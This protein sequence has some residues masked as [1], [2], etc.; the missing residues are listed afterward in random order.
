MIKLF[1]RNVVVKRLPGKRLKAF[2]V[3][4]TQMTGP[5]TSTYSKARWRRNTATGGYGYGYINADIESLRKSMYV[6]YD[7]MD[8]DG[9]IASALDLYADECTT[10]SENG[11]LLV[12][13]SENVQVKKIL[14]NLFYD[15]LNIEFNLWSWMRTACKYGDY[16]LFMDIR[17]EYGVVNVTPCHPGLVIREEGHPDHPDR[18]Q[19]SYDGDV[20]YYR[21]YNKL[22][23]FEVAHFRLITDPSFLPYGR[24]IIEPARKVYKSLTLM[25]DAMLLYRI[26]R[27]PERRLFKID[28]GLIPPDE[29]DTYIESLANTMKKTPIFDENTGEFNM[30][31]NIANSMED[32]FIPTRGGE[33]GT[34]IETLPGL[35]NQGQIDDINYL[36]DKMHAALKIPRS[37]LG[38]E[39]SGENAKAG[40]ATVDIRFARTIERIQKVFVSELY[41]IAVVHLKAQGFED[42]EL[43]NFELY[44]TNPS[45]IYERQKIELLAS[46]MELIATIRENNIF[47]DKY[48]YEVILNMTED[49]WIE[50]HDNL[51]EDLKER[52]RE[53][54]IL[55]EGNDPV[56]SGRSFGTPHAIATIH[57]A[58]NMDIDRSEEIKKLYKD[59]QRQYNLGQPKKNTNFETRRNSDFGSDPTGKKGME[60]AAGLESFVKSLQKT[61]FRKILKEKHPT[62]IK[63]LN[64]NNLLENEI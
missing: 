17:E 44:L 54:Q 1:T 2:D 46:K 63:M 45:L 33:S 53:K 7:L 29:I 14:H 9:L 4:K 59:D 24:S 28:V 19:F 56:I 25:E 23:A 60:K 35:Q 38:G 11:E 27:A 16:F 15:I 18:V 62:E 37:F 41:K 12:I 61:D 21:S 31:Y 13:K 50:N 8:T 51:I 47:S 64:E 42:E 22:E 43:L 39:E 10:V 20:S 49:E 6:D 52:F 57:M 48:I 36:K 30:K 32:Y 34:V 55:E 3:N 40:L 58:S 5:N 26:T